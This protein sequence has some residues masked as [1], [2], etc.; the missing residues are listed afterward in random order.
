MIAWAPCVADSVEHE[1]QRV[2]W[3][4]RETLTT[5]STWPAQRVWDIKVVN[6]K[7]Q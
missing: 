5:R 4:Y 2:R 6:I 1:E 3:E 7:P